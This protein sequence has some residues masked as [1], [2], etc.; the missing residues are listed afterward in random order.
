MVDLN[1][2]PSNLTHTRPTYATP[3]VGGQQDE[4]LSQEDKQTKI[5]NCPTKS[6]HRSQEEEEEE[7][8]HKD[9][10]EQ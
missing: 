2:N 4:H 5:R 7:K 1:A 6:R 9:G 3:E 10:Q 8:H